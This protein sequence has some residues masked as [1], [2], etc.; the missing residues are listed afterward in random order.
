[1]A[2]IEKLIVSLKVQRGENPENFLKSQRKMKAGFA[3]FD[4]DKPLF[5]IFSLWRPRTFPNR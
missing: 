1:M 4:V 3:D 2:L 5:R